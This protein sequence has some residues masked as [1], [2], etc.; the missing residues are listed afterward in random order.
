MPA[1][2]LMQPPYIV[3]VGVMPG[4]YFSKR[5]YEEILNLETM[6]KECSDEH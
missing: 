4:V 5:D 6:H 1:I 3:E 2:H